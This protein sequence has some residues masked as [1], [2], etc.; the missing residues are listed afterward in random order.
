MFEKYGSFDESFRAYAD[1]RHFAQ[2]IAIG[3]E[4][5]EFIPKKISIYE[6]GGISETNEMLCKH[7][8]DRIRAEV[9]PNIDIEEYVML[10]KLDAVCRFCVSEFCLRVVSRIITAIFPILQKFKIYV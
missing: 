10:R 8:L 3:K 9:Y 1:W 6:G 4:S 5:T 7:E 2:M